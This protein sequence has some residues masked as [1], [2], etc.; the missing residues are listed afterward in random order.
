MAEAYIN[1]VATAVPAY[2]VHH[3]FRDFAQSLFAGDRRRG[4][5]FKRMAAL[6]GI[7]LAI[8]QGQGKADLAMGYE[9]DIIASSVVGGA[10][11]SP[12]IAR[13]ARSSAGTKRP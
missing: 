8:V 2:D 11:L 4:A 6:S 7:A 10:S 13:G 12:R 9:L 3:T 5:I 1:R